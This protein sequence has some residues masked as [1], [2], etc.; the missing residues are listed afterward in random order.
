MYTSSTA[1]NYPSGCLLNS[2]YYLTSALTIIGSSSFTDY[3][4]TTTITGH[5]GDGFIKII[6]ISANDSTTY[7][8][9]VSIPS[10]DNIKTNDVL[11]CP[12]SGT[13]KTLNL[14]KG[15]YKLE[16]WGA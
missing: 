15:I 8:L 12:Y 16:C 3:D 6:V 10:A 9:T 13:S 1:S 2:N 14:N 4:G 7:D 5:A 11:N